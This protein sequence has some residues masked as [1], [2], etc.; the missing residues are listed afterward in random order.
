MPAR[1]T[2][3]KSVRDVVARNIVGKGRFVLVNCD[4]DP[5]MVLE[6]GLGI[7]EWG[8]V[9]DAMLK[10]LKLKEPKLKEQIEEALLQNA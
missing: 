9:L 1:Q 3:P 4:S 2:L 10:H 7:D 5:P 6:T 8:S